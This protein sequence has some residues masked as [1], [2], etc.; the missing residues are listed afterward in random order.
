[1]SNFVFFPDYFYPWLMNLALLVLPLVVFR[2]KWFE[3][4]SKLASIIVP[5]GLVFALFITLVRAPLTVYVFGAP[6]WIGLLYFG[7][8]LGLYYFF[9]KYYNSVKAISL[10]FFIFYYTSMMFI[11][12]TWFIQ[13]PLWYVSS[14]LILGLMIIPAYFVF[15]LKLKNLVYFFPQFLVTIPVAFTIAPAVFMAPDVTSEPWAT[16]CRITTLIC[17]FLTLSINTIRSKK[18]EAST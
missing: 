16:I 6:W 8:T 18:H 13:P 11:A 9:R 7:G 14:E 17:I 12:P 1:M 15:Q 5:A 10:S 3:R 4:L 2:I